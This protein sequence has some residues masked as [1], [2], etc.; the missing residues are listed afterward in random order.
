EFTWAYFRPGGLIEI[1]SGAGKDGKLTAWEFHNY[2][3]GG[4][5][6]RALYEVPNQLIEFHQCNSPLQ[7]GSYRALASTANHFARETA[8]DELAHEL[9]IDPLEFRLRNLKDERL[10]AVL[11]AAAKAFGWGKSK[12]AQNH[13]FGIAGG[14]EKA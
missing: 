11:S 14:F 7:Q 8:I 9:R 6:I 2:N 3:S 4:A 1:S 12:P 5:G 10:R 13:G